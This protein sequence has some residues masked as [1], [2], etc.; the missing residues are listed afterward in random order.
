LFLGYCRKELPAAPEWLGDPRVSRIASIS[1]GV[2]ERPE[3]WT[4]RWD[5]NAAGLYDT[6]G[7]ADAEVADLDRERFRLFAFTMTPVR[8]DI[9][10]GET[11]VTS[12][13]VFGRTF[14]NL[15]AGHPVEGFRRLGY[16]VVQRWAEW[17]PGCV[18]PNSLA[19]G[20]GCSPLSC[21]RRSLDFDVTEHCLLRTWAEARRA[22]LD[23][24][25]AT[26][27]EPGCYYVF[28][29]YIQ[30]DAP[31][32]REAEGGLSPSIHPITPATTPRRSRPS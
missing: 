18:E 3:G 26:N 10:G 14:T 12:E 6:V 1:Q 4:D 23:F 7:A 5:F 30:A 17:E 27:S 16:D 29:V 32:S 9:H 25:T 21:N 24:A 22:A 2:A 20:F 19:A 8:F 28:G 11:T 15:Y 31:G 13:F